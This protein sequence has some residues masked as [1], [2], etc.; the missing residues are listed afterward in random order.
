MSVSHAFTI[1]RRITLCAS[2]YYFKHAVNYHA[3]G[4]AEIRV[5]MAVEAPAT[6]D[7]VTYY[8]RPSDSAEVT[9]YNAPCARR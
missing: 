3:A 4:Q 5:T 8:S 7:A 9:S 2:T 6:L 1:R